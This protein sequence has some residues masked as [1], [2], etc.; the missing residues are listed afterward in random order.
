MNC[1]GRS[2]AYA[3]TVIFLIVINFSATGKDGASPASNDNPK[4]RFRWTDH[5][6]LSWDDFKGVV[7]ATDNEAAAATFCSIG[8]KTNAATPG[9]TPQI[10]V[11]NTF[12][13]NK[14]WVRADARIASILDHEQ[15]HFDLCEIYTRKLRDRL[16]NIDLS[17][18]G[19]KQTLMHIYGELS[20]EYEERQQ[21]YEQET[22]HGT[23]IAIQKKWQQM[24]ATELTGQ[25]GAQS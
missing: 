10:E 6:R 23:N 8:F 22:T 3:L 18:P 1:V 7:T 24:I 16:H 4:D 11:Y 15:G 17:A 5:A 2:C 13:V 14:S 21:A 9:D 19:I 12:Y 25:A 20:R